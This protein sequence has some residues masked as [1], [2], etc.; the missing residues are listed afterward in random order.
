MSSEHFNIFLFMMTQAE[1]EKQ[2]AEDRAAL[3]GVTQGDLAIAAIL[4]IVER[5]QFLEGGQAIAPNL[6]SEVR[7]YNAGRCAGVADVAA[8]LREEIPKGK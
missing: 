2:V 4:R 7:H 1:M 5:Q 6:P 8:M 3:S